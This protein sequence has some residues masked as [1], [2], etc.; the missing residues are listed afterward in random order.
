MAINENSLTISREP[1]GF[2]AIP[3]FTNDGKVEFFTGISSLAK[4]C[5]LFHSLEDQIGPRYICHG[6][7]Q[8]PRFE[9]FCLT[10]M[11]LRLN[12]QPTDLSQLFKLPKFQV[13]VSISQF[14]SSMSVTLVP[15]FLQWR[16]YVDNESEAFFPQLVNS[17]GNPTCNWIIERI[18]VRV[19]NEGTLNY[20]VAFSVNGMVS[21]VSPGYPNL[22]VQGAEKWKLVSLLEHL[23]HDDHVLLKIDDVINI[24]VCNESLEKKRLR[25]S[26]FAGSKEL[27]DA[28][29]WSYFAWSQKILEPFKRRFAVFCHEPFKVPISA[30]MPVTLKVEQIVQ[31]CCALHNFDSLISNN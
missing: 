30:N 25:K 5:S 19:A 9:Q 10:L 3:F 26:T 11:N 13:S 20:F 15:N 8:V 27:S 31:I 18:K 24:Y 12:L 28:I 22:L 14:I 6:L 1:N 29:A 21:Y 4:L 2:S 7:D 17:N 16:R 23:S